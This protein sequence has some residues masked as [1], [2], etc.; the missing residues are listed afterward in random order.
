MSQN[1]VEVGL[2]GALP[3]TGEIFNV[4]EAIAAPAEQQ[5]HEEP[6]GFEVMMASAQNAHT[7]A[8]LQA[9]SAAQQADIMHSM[10]EAGMPME[11]AFGVDF[12]HAGAGD[13]HFE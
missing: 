5:G 1:A 11:Q 13:F 9:T 6:S 8:E 2:A 10:N 3:G 7:I 12:G 4:I